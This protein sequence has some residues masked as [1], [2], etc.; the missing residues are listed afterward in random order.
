MTYKLGDYII[1]N[2]T[3]DIYICDEEIFKETYNEII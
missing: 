1:K 3:G 2:I